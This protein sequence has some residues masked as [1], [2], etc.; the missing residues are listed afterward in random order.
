VSES[1]QGGARKG[2]G[3]KHDPDARRLTISAKVNAEEMLIAE[4]LGWGNASAGVRAAL[5]FC[6]LTD[7]HLRESG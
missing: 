2:A 5:A 1:K 6:A 4:R 3:R 7:P